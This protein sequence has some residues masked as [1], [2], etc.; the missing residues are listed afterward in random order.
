MSA[1]KVT[2]IDYELGNLLSVRRGLEHCGA[3]VTIT[4]DVEQ[5]RKSERVVL[6]GVGTFANG[7]ECLIR[8]DIDDA[9]HELD[10]RKTPLLGICLGMQLL[11]S[12]SQEFGLTKGLGLI[13]GSVVPI[14]ALSVDNDPLK[15]PFIGWSSLHPSE[16]RV[17]WNE[18][19]L[20]ENSIGA[21]MY[22]VHSFMASPKNQDNRIADYFYGGNRISAV[23][24]S[25][26]VIGCQFHPE[27]SGMNG[28][29]VLKQFL[30]L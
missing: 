7:M 29:N 26:N 5:I 20:R 28:L 30:L 27:K 15:V 13:A 22:F 18:T 23:V 21:E 11:F 1:P 9:V 3:D 19:I 10:Q 6:P 4:S 8:L 2:L 16:N 12:E 17:E 14:S 25:E 24:S